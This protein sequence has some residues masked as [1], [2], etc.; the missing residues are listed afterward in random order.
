MLPKQEVSYHPF[1]LS[2]P[3]QT[4]VLQ[5]YQNHSQI[6]KCTWSFRL[7]LS[8]HTFPSPEMLFPPSFHPGNYCM[9]GTPSSSAVSEMKPTPSAPQMSV[10]SSRLHST[11]HKPL[12][13]LCSN[14][15]FTSRRLLLG[16]L[17]AEVKF[18]FSCSTGPEHSVVAV[19]QV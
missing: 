17:E 1:H 4:P 18:R 3:F 6:L 16:S 8:L 15:L 11:W 19:A 7:P 9:P 10:P 12:A 5:S 14:D 13:T 2:T